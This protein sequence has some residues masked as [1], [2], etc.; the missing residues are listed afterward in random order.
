LTA[1]YTE[2]GLV[3]SKQVVKTFTIGVSVVF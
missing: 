2:G 3:L 1:S